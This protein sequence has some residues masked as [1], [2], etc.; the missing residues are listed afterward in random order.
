MDVTSLRRRRLAAIGETATSGTAARDVNVERLTELRQSGGA[1]DEEDRFLREVRLLARLEHPNIP[2]VH[3]LGRNAEGRLFRTVK[4]PSQQTLESKLEELAAGATME[5][6]ARLGLFEKIVDAVAFAHDKGVI[7]GRLYPAR[8]HLGD[9]GEVLV[10][11]WEQARDLSADSDN[12]TSVETG[13][14]LPAEG[15]GAPESEASPGSD[16]FSLGALLHCLLRSL[17]AAAF[18]PTTLSKSA[19]RGV[20]PALHAVACMAMSDEPDDRYDSVAE[21]LA[22]IG[23]W[24]KGYATEAEGAGFIR[25]FLLLGLRNKVFAATGLVIGAM[26]VWF[27]GNL[28][29]SWTAAQQHVKELEKHAP[30]LHQVAMGHAERQEWKE[31][32]DK[33]NAAIALNESVADFHL[34]RGEI[35][36]AQLDAKA[37]R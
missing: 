21:L 28:W 11:D 3:Q 32:L 25:A 29:N 26:V 37:A 34:L 36:L 14:A 16:I 13:E 19:P 31:A 5:T 2:P 18:D 1:V 9:H 17:P 10:D 27:L 24:K 22:D 15:F 12:G 30:L 4:P 8:I 35:H 33:V 7:H 23:R 20:P 6:E